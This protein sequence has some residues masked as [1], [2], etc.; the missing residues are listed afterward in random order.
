VRLYVWRK[1]IERHNSQVIKAINASDSKINQI[2]SN[3]RLL[4][5]M[6]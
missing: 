2:K 3:V 6:T 4:I 1:K 5:G